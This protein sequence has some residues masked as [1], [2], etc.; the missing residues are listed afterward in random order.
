MDADQQPVR[1]HD[2]I[3]RSPREAYKLNYG[4]ERVRMISPVLVG[5][6]V[7]ARIVLKAARIRD[8][9]ILCNFDFTVEIR[10]QPR[11]ALVAEWLALL[12]ERKPVAD[13]S[14]RTAI[15]AA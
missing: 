4:L 15:D 1:H 7:R 8:P 3:A 12:V 5:S 10:D 13:V 9:G 11:P 6:S 14:S 2:V